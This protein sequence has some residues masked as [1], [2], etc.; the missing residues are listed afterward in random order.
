MHCC[1]VLRNLL[2]TDTEL[3]LHVESAGGELVLRLEWVLAH[4][5]GHVHHLGLLLNSET[6]SL[7][8]DCELTRVVLENFAEVVDRR[9]QGLHELGVL[10]HCCSDTLRSHSKDL[11]NRQA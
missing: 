4:R 2:G 1:N 6:H 9:A 3:I 8:I 11:G 5:L 10:S 7:A